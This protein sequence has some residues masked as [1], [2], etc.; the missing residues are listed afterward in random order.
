LRRRVQ[1]SKLLNVNK[2][3]SPSPQVIDR[4]TKSVTIYRAAT[5]STVIVKR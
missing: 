4:S 3:T 1:M 5:P 2:N